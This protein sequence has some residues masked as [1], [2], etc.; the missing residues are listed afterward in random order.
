MGYTGDLPRII[1]TTYEDSAGLCVSKN[2][3]GNAL[4]R[5]KYNES[6]QLIHYE[7]AIWIED[8]WFIT[9]TVT[10]R[11]A[12]RNLQESIY[13][14]TYP[15]ANTPPEI[16]RHVFFGGLPSLVDT[17]VQ[18][19]WSDDS[20]WVSSFMMTTEKDTRMNGTTETFYND[21]DG[22][23]VRSNQRKNHY[24][25]QNRLTQSDYEIWN[26]AGDLIQTWGMTYDTLG[27][28]TS[29]WH[30][31][32]LSEG[33]VEGNRYSLRYW[34]PKQTFARSHNRT[35]PRQTSTRR[36][37]PFGSAQGSQWLAIGR[38]KKTMNALGQV[39]P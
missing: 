17:T 33:P 9:N 3:H 37:R 7:N 22:H 34:E 25:G 24:D 8:H 39:L 14:Q 11:Y 6:G 15:E 19:R 20:G 26:D 21:Q 10:H 16:T 32:G 18:F 2:T 4:E 35:P 23:W 31:Y 29:E 1:F 36:M 30:L 12:G 27:R 38:D 28:T 13:T 5:W